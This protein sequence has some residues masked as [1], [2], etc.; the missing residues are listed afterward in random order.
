[1][2]DQVEHP[3][4]PNIVVVLTAL[5]VEY[6][7]VRQHLLQ[8]EARPH[9]AGTLFEVG[10]LPGA[11]GM[12][13]LAQT[14]EGNVG[15]AVLAERAIAAFRPRALL[16]AGIAGGLKDDIA[17]GDIVV[18]TKIYALHSGREHDDGFLPRPRSWLASHQLQ[19]LAQHLARTGTWARLVPRHPG[20]PD[21]RSPSQIRPAVVHF[22][23][24]A[25]GEVVLTATDTSLRAL[26]RRTYDDAAAVEMESAG[27]AQA[28]HLNGSLPT[29]SVRGISDHAD[30]RK[31]VTDTASWQHIA[32]ERAAAFSVSLA[33]LAMRNP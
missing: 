20:D 1:M 18:A 13:A 8:P 33:A 24:V 15:A 3:S 21:G 19:Q 16:C 6:Q 26:L 17:L 27:T 23:P 10:R 28:A 31:H 22:K 5:P 30:A 12:I 14:G 7:A 9:P 25:S 29:L 32:A 11:A 2:M 4:L